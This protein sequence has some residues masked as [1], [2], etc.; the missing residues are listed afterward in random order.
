M[1]FKHGYSRYNDNKDSIS[2]IE[3]IYDYYEGKSIG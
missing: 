1:K 3:G 2:S